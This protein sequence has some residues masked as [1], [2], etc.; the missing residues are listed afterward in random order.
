M[1]QTQVLIPLG[2]ISMLLCTLC[3]NPQANVLIAHS[4]KGPGLEQLFSA[5]ETFLIPLRQVEMDLAA[6]GGSPS[7]SFERFMAIYETVRQ[8]AA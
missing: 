6:N 2:Y 8:K 5:V 3:L 1:D 7:G 4:T